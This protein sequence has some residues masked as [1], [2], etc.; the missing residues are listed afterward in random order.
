MK[1]ANI[2]NM[3]ILPYIEMLPKNT[4]HALLMEVE[5]D[6]LFQKEHSTVCVYFVTF[7]F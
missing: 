7:Y 1:F 5:S 4:I 6:R 2:N 3:L